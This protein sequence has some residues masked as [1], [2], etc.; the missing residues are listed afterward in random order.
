M[1][2]WVW[3]ALGVA[4]AA[5]AITVQQRLRPAAC[6]YGARLFVQVPHPLIGRR[7]LREILAAASGERV[8]EVG[9]GTGYYTLDLAE[10]VGPQGEVAIFDIQQEFLDHTMR[11]AGERGLANV[12]PARGSAESLPYEDASFDAAVLITVLGEIPDQHRALR[13]L[14]RVLKPGGRL[15]VGEMMLGDPHYTSPAAVRARGEAAGL[16][17]ERRVGSRAGYFARLVKS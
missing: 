10:W 14:H 3:I 6:P 1:P 9:P 17:F 16:R 4:V 15:I 12:K 8:L 7:R 2:W 11:R 5:V 13:E